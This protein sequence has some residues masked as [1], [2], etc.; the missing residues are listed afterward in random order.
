MKKVAEKRAGSLLEVVKQKMA[1]R[2]NKEDGHE[3]S[4]T[5]EN[6]SSTGS[7]WSEDEEN[8]S[9]QVLMNQIKQLKGE[10]K[11]LIQELAAANGNK[12]NTIEDQKIISKVIISY[13]CIFSRSENAGES[14]KSVDGSRQML[15]KSSTIITSIDSN[16]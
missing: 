8:E 4:E 3:E 5:D 2:D 11:R 7:S 15:R 16:A 13:H 9:K 6:M 12:K 1:K 10:N 14:R